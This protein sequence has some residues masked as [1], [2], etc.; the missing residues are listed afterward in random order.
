MCFIFF[1]LTTIDVRIA[2][3]QEKQL[4]RALSEK[5]LGSTYA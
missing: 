2:L 4:E 1:Q 5:H 3:W